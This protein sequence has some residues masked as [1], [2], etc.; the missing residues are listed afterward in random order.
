MTKVPIKDLVGRFAECDYCGA[1]GLVEP[2]RHR[3]TAM[4][5]FGRGPITFPCFPP[6]KIQVEAPS[7]PAVVPW[8][9]HYTFMCI[10]CGC[11]SLAEHTPLVPVPDPE[12]VS[13]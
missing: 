8:S 6:G 11:R 3:P 12:E 9:I 5:Q 13:P 10:R 2:P 4:G 7:G 1:P